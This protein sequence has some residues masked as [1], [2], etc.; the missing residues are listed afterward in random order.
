MQSPTNSIPSPSKHLGM[1]EVDSYEIRKR[2][3][4][5]IQT[6]PEPSK[7]SGGEVRLS[8]GGSGVQEEKNFDFVEFDLGQ[9]KKIALVEKRKNDLKKNSKKVKV[10]FSEST[11]TKKIEEQEKPDKNSDGEEQ[12]P[13]SDPEDNQASKEVGETIR[14]GCNRDSV[15]QRR[16]NDKQEDPD[17]KPCKGEKNPPN[18]EIEMKKI[19]REDQLKTSEG[20][21][22]SEAISALEDQN[23]AMKMQ[24]ILHLEKV[25]EKLKDQI[26]ALKAQ[27]EIGDAHLIKENQKLK[28]DLEILKNAQ[29]SEKSLDQKIK[30]LEE[31]KAEISQSLIEAARMRREAKKLKSKNEKKTFFFQQWTEKIK[32]DSSKNQEMEKTLSDMKKKLDARLAQVN[33]RKE[34]ELEILK[35]SNK[36]LIIQNQALRQKLSETTENNAKTPSQSSTLKS[37]IFHQNQKSSEFSN[38]FEML[39]TKVKEQRKEIKLVKER[40]KEEDSTS[41]KINFFSKYWRGKLNDIKKGQRKLAEKNFKYKEGLKALNMQFD[42]L[43]KKEIQKIRD[44][45]REFLNQ[46]TKEINERFDDKSL[47][48]MKKKAFESGFDAGV[49]KYE[50]KLELITKKYKKVKRLYKELLNKREDD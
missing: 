31:M 14:D 20:R 32:E 38:I 27:L 45:N 35:Q 33:Q 12:T 19:V 46:K 22:Q 23:T 47:E 6:T 29:K 4:T 5:L 39:H 11:E 13:L 26:K 48:K 10:E 1:K 17:S 41:V 28:S 44:S 49:E 36:E 3:Q 30:R 9:H 34:S 25:N 21:I 42:S 37:A 7:R 18:T 50:D 15:D 2:E 16:E 43:I 8:S 24:I 40:L